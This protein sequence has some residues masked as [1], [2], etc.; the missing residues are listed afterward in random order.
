MVGEEL[1]RGARAPLLTH[2]QHRGEGAGQDEGCAD[3]QQPGAER[4]ADAVAL[5]AVADLVVILQVGQKAPSGG[6]FPVDGAAVIAAAEGGPAAVVH[7]HR[8]EN[9]GQRAQG[10][11]VDVVALPLTGQCRVQRMVDVVRPLR[12]Q[13]VAP[14][15]AR[16]DQPRVVQVALGDQEQRPPDV[17][18][19]R[20]HLGGHLLQQVGRPVV[21]Q[22]VHGIE[23]QPVDV[24]VPQ[25]HPDVVQ[26]K[27]AD[28]VR[29]G[30]VQV[31]RWP[32]G[33]GV[34][35]GEVR[36]ELAQ[37]VT[38]RP[39]VVVDHIHHDADAPRVAGVHEALQP[40][41][42]A[43]GVL[44]GVQPHAVVAPTVLPG[45]RVHRQQLDGA[46]PEVDEVVE[47]PD[48]GVEGALVGERAD[49]QLVD[50]SARQR[51]SPP[52]LVRP[53]EGAEID[54]AARAV[55]AVRLP[56]RPRIGQRR[57]VVDREGVV[58]AGVHRL[59]QLPPAVGPRRRHRTAVV[60]DNHR[61]RLGA[62]RPHS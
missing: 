8:R 10:P 26:N 32:P 17:C 54:D 3:L 35:V 18:G 27:G 52:Q 40:V 16:G 7:E 42:A 23:A 46:D 57:P 41:G 13:P 6:A 5:G 58:R 24:V 30:G 51:N 14:G 28:L 22:G 2:P 55:H 53:R 25:P 50:D 59:V 48:G 47:F 20:R 29:A 39:Q 34:G 49:V 31:D 60:A 33:C 11:E 1:P 43:V 12:V 9:L 44:H 19:K 36:P 45:E 37:V 15:L 61:H 56:R 62:G 4:G 38:G 21:L